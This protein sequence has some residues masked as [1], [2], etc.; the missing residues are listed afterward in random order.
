MSFTPFITQLFACS[1]AA[2]ITDFDAWMQQLQAH[3][4]VQ[5]NSTARALLAGV[6]ADRLGFAF[7][8]GY[9][10]ALQR[11]IND[12][13]PRISALC[14]TEM[15]GNQPRHIETTLTFA[16]NQWLL[17]GEKTFVTLADR[18]EW[19][20]V[21][22]CSGE[23]NGRKHIKLVGIAANQPGVKLELLP[24]LAF[25]PEIGHA[26]VR[27]DDVVVAAENVLPGDGYTEYI[28]PFRTIEDIHVYAACCG[29]LLGHAL[30]L[31]WPESAVTPW[32]S[33]AHSWLHLASEPASA[34]G[35]HLALAGLM[36]QQR[37]LIEIV[38]P[39]IDED[40]AFAARW[41]R[42]LPLVK[43]AE[44]ARQIRTAKAWQQLMEPTLA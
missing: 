24:M 3:W 1:V 27:F 31:R 26:R 19:L 33:L 12:T 23:S 32:L 9:C 6:T 11:L 35:T 15:G 39:L 36:A 21:A 22:A 40:A 8:G 7:A 42:D 34:P 44:K 17:N 2:P 28:K 41:Q 20:W 10:A 38:T 4:Q 25:V 18:A 13:T 5:T 37:Q 30:R 43:V 29:L 14:A 16:N